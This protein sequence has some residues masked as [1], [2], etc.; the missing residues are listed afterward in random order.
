MFQNR[1]KKSVTKEIDEQVCIPEIVGK[2]YMKNKKFN[3]A[4]GYVEE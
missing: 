2:I 3:V 1:N 4:Y